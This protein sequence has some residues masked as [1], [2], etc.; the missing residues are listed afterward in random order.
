MCN[1]K[2]VPNTNLLNQLSA[3]IIL[4]KILYGIHI[5]ISI[6][7]YINSVSRGNQKQLFNRLVN[8]IQS[9]TYEHCVFAYSKNL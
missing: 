7:I 5:K 6:K 2:F 9:K 8:I 4:N 3:D 1:D